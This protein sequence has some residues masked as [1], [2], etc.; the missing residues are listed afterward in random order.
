R[1]RGRPRKVKK[2][3]DD[4][5]GCSEKDV[6][7]AIKSK[8]FTPASVPSSVVTF[9]SRSS[10]S[11]EPERINMFH[12]ELCRP[13]VRQMNLSEALKFGPVP[14]PVRKLYELLT[15][16]PCGYIPKELKVTV[17]SNLHAENPLTDELAT[18]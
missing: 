14:E 7:K 4:E 1:G 11:I 17:V 13:G 15:D 12:L 9:P 10:S 3:T 2:E 16:T 18:L 6:S 5:I 8:P